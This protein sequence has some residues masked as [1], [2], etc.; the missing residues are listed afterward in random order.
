MREVVKER[1]QWEDDRQKKVSD[2][3]KGIGGF[4]D[5]NLTELLIIL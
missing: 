3:H 2:H 1:K 4:Y 5:K